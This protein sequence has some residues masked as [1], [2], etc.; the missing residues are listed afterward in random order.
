MHTYTRMC[1]CV[2]VRMRV[3]VLCMHVCVVYVRTLARLSDKDGEPTDA[4]WRLPCPTGMVPEDGRDGRG[5]PERLRQALR[6]VDPDT[7][8][9]TRKR[10]RARV[11]NDAHM[12][13]RV[14][15]NVYACMLR[16]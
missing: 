9:C 15:C 13:Q 2:C 10:A 4:R 6:P 8:A 16:L 11:S 1:V 14:C 5:D 7:G 3:Y 12:R